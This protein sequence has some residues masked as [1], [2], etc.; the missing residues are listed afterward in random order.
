M[1]R[2]F[3]G[4]KKDPDS[5]TKCKKCE[6]LIYKKEL[7]QNL[8]VCPK[9]DY[10]FRITAKQR[11]TQVVDKNT[12]KE[13][14][15]E[16][17]SAD[18]LSFVDGKESYINKV[19]RAIKKTGQKSAVIVGTGKISGEPVAIAILDFFFMGG[20]LGSAM[21]EKIVRIVEK[22]IEKRIPLIIVSASG[23]ARMHEGVY[24]LMQLVKTSVVLAKLHEER[25]PFISVV[26]DPTTGGVSASFATQA[27]IIIAEPKALIG[28][29]GPRVIEQTIK[30]KLPK[31]FQTAEFLLEKGMVDMVVHRKKLKDT[32][33]KLL[34]LFK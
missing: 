7:A 22:A 32:L 30:Q 27:D 31:D 33:G 5:W 24:S 4:F 14:A 3:K 6:E 23:G 18:P 2:W 34:K 16:V 9:C 29:A 26:C 8:Y 11:L 20:S 28:F 17:T 13:Y 15:K 12:F 21:G 1:M 25:L 19:A 10:H